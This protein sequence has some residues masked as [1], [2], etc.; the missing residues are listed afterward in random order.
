MC[1]LK[2]ILKTSPDLVLIDDYDL[3]SRACID[4]AN[5]TKGT[6]VEI[7][8]KI[9]Y[10]GRTGRNNEKYRWLLK[11]IR[12][13]EIPDYG[14]KNTEVLAYLKEMGY[15]DAKQKSINDGLKNLPRIL[16]KNNIISIFDYDGTHFYLLDRYMKFVLKWFPEI[17]D[18]LFKLETKDEEDNSKSILQINFKPVKIEPSADIID[19]I[20]KF[21]NDLITHVDIVSIFTHMTITSY[22]S[23]T[24]TAEIQHP[25]L[26][27]RNISV[28]DEQYKYIVNKLK[29]S[30]IV[31]PMDNDIDNLLGFESNVILFYLGFLYCERYINYERVEDKSVRIFLTDEATE[32]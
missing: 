7:L 14:I 24:M 2:G 11:M 31:L 13:K 19:I 22:D 30:D 10:G 28:D 16:D 9:S 4:I 8:K 27:R 6:Y 5:E 32:R 18:N 20:Q 23:K 3:F 15:Y 1:E 21:R 25:V 17:I 29:L 26:G 12:E